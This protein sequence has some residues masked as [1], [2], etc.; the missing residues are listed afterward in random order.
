M[1]SWRRLGVPA[2][3]VATITLGAIGSAQQGSAPL[4]PAARLPLPAGRVQ[5]RQWTRLGRGSSTSATIRPTT[6]RGYDFKRDI[7]EKAADRRAAMRRPAKACMDF[8]KIT[9]RSSVGDM[10]IPAYLFQ[11]LKKRGATRA[12]GHGLGARRR[13][14][15]LGRQ[16]VSVRQRSGRARLRRHLSRVSRQHRI[17]RGAPQRDRLRRLRDRRHDERRRLPEDACRTSISE[18]LGIMGWSH[19]G[20]IT[21]LSVFRDTH[22]FKAAAAMVPVTNLVFRLSYKGPGYQRSFSTQPRI[23]G[24]AVR[25]ARSLHRALA[26]LSRRQA[27]DP[28][29]RPRR[30]QRHRRQLRR[31]SADRRRAAFAQ[32]GSGGDEGVCRSRTGTGKRRPHVQPPR[33]PENARARRF[34]GSARFVEPHVDVLRVAPASVRGS[35]PTADGDG[36]QGVIMSR[37]VLV[38]LVLALTSL[39]PQAEPVIIDTPM[40]APA[41]ARLE[42][43]ILADNVPAC[44]EFF[45]KYYDSARLP[46]SVPALGRERRA[47]RC[48]RELQSLARA[49]R[50]GRG[51]RDP[52]ALSHGLGG[53]DPPVL[54]SEDQRR[55]RG[56]RRHVRQGF[57]RAVGLDAPRRRAAALQP[58][59]AV[60][61][62]P[63]RLSRARRGAS[64]GSTWERTP[65]APNYDPE[66]S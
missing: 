17:R 31:G 61:A 54:R 39:A 37:T 24:L 58:H 63:A 15:Q 47:G 57:L 10:D 3:A 16:H 22:P 32:A 14:W 50:A 6:R 27:E 65:D 64:P 23:R 51:R 52:A 62:G 59:G 55:A 11:P 12:C 20:Y 66:R 35:Q 28:A 30:D 21:L 2:V 38:G 4:Q 9:Y 45:Q 25:E 46:S 48:V 19:G 8:Q 42:R 60:G 18:R 29:A 41:W 26:A 5:S 40:P 49:P 33:E 34:T 1:P 36:E 13:A 53:D 43:R 7:A 44:R 56:P